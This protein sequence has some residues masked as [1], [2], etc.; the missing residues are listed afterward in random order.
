MAQGY[1]FSAVESGVM[2]FWSSAK[3][4]EKAVSKNKGKKA[5]YFLDGPPYT[6]G[7]VHLG[8]AWNK[9]I[10][11]CVLR[12]KRMRSLDVWDRAGY[13]MH[14]L[15]TE[16]EVQKR[17]GLKHKEDILKFGVAK[18]VEE[19]RHFAIGN[20]LSMNKDFRRLGVWM[21]FDNAYQT[22]SQEWIEGEW[23]LVK[24]AH[25]QNRLYEGERTMTWCANCGSALAKHELD[26]KT[27]TEKSV[28]VKFR[29]AGKENEFLIIWTTTPWTLPFNLAVMVNPEL[30]YVRAAVDSEVWI[31]SKELAAAVVR[32]VADKEI[33]V[34]EAF[35]GEKLDGLRY[36]HPF[37]E[38]VK[39]FKALRKKSKR[40]HS[41]IL[42]KEYV[43]VSAG[44][45][46][47]HC[48][49]GCGPE[50]YEV[51]YRYKI[52][53]YNS[54]SESGIFPEGMG[55]FSGL[56]AKKDDDVFIKE[57]EKLGALVA[58][59]PVEHEY[60]HCWRCGE[61]VIY[62]ATRQWFFKVE[63]LKERML[64]ENR[65][66]FWQPDWAGSRWFD[67]WL[68][69]LRDNSITKQRF[70][71]TP[72]PVWRCKRCKDY[73]VVGSVEEL[74]KLSGKVPKDLHKP[75]I[76]EILLPCKCGGKKE[77]I[78]DIIDVWV[79]AGSASWNCLNF[80]KKKELFNK[81]FPADFITEGKDQIR[82]WFN[83]LVVAAMVAMD[84]QPF[85]SVY[86]HGHVMDAAGRKMSKSL[87]NYILPQEVIDKYGAD[88]F[89]YYS[90]AGAA[91]GLD[92]NYNMEDV[93][94]KHRNLMVLWNVHRYLIDYSKEAG[95]NPA[96]QKPKQL[97]AEEKYILSKANSAIAE[98]TNMFE[99]L[100]LNEVPLE[101][102]GLFLELS[103]T[104]IKLT[105]EKV[106]E[107]P[108]TVLP[109]IHDTLV[110]CLKLFAPVAPFITE[111]I[112]QNL[113]SEFG[114]KE[115]SV[116][117]CAWPSAKKELVDEELEQSFEHAKAV[118][119]AIL[120][121]RERLQMGVRWPLGEAVVVYSDERIGR[122]LAKLKDVVRSQANIKKVE[123]VDSFSKEKVVVRLDKGRVDQDFK[124][125][126]AQ[127]M[128]AFEHINTKTVLRHIEQDGKF[129]LL[130]GKEK[131][132]LT[133]EHLIVERK[134]DG[135]ESESF[136][137]GLVFLCTKVT[138]ELEAE[139]YFREVTRRVQSARKA[140]GLRKSD[141]IRLTLIFDDELC[142]QLSKFYEQI[143]EKV[144]AESLEITSEPQAE[145]AETVV[146]EKVKKKSF[147]ILFS[148]LA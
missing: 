135:Y 34:I 56:T 11:D 78:Q 14:G 23:W 76:D 50:D 7:K 124:S 10:K 96:R 37:E 74:R 75:W 106:S 60:A 46:L 72:L 94:A 53:P 148:R 137:G 8:T 79:D 139:G 3:I 28:F 127:V 110:A 35:K 112:Y 80:P 108:E 146:Q 17:L 125:K 117:L 98:A 42:S 67:S 51:G 101:A 118:I 114:L 29:V 83:L 58:V 126:S 68:Q 66:V 104:Y 141:R 84:R 61:P 65:Q 63:D 109:V 134:A 136:R 16:R 119:Q 64:A 92:L 5:F 27:V 107:E 140:A 6:S 120:S 12:Y 20:L 82:G 145:K 113:K 123:V 57:L 99:E 131:V 25:T 4:Y 2:E 100:R 116:H 38:E 133:Q 102:E 132:Q 44:T 30:D 9:S 24:Q 81:L 21:D 54:L 143:K 47:V 13:D 88:T 111:Q 95:I 26:Y 73:A 18:F 33:K 31:L 138:P 1:D 128:S 77:R 130:V 105:R 49:P 129:E 22:V 122:G 90:I 69:N 144:G 55:R 86:M 40:I 89:R 19:C 62:R 115:E 52:P 48:A 87:G 103:R 85:R 71:G 15:P 121:M 41:V 43:D 147:E 59:T 70:W 39:E 36:E 91:P 45:G 97:S 142:K 32:G 93:K